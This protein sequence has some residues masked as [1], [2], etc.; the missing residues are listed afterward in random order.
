MAAEATGNDAATGSDAITPFDRC[1]HA[2]IKFKDLPAVGAALAAPG[3]DVNKIYRK[4][5]PLVLAVQM[6]W[7]EGVEVLSGLRLLPSGK[8]NPVA[9][10]ID[11]NAKDGYG[12]APIHYAVLKAD[13]KMVEA[14]LAK[15]AR[16]DTTTPKCQTPLH[17]CLRRENKAVSEIEYKNM[18]AFLIDAGSPLEAADKWGYTAL[19]RAADRGFTELCEHILSSCSRSLN[20]TSERRWGRFSPLMRSTIKG[21]IDTV[22][23]LMA[24]GADIHLKSEDGRQ[25]LNWAASHGHTYICKLLIDAGASLDDTDSIGETA[26]LSAVK[27]YKTLSA[28][29]LLNEG[30]NP[31]VMN[32][33]GEVA[34][35][36]ALK[37]SVL[38]AFE[39][40]TTQLIEA[41]G[42]VHPFENHMKN[43]LDH[44]LMTASS[45]GDERIV[46]LLVG[47]GSVAD[48]R[49][50]RGLNAIYM[51]VKNAHNAVVKLLLQNG[52]D[53]N[54]CDEEGSTILHHVM[55]RRDMVSPNKEEIDVVLEKAV[56]RA[57]EERE[58]REEE[59]RKEE[60]RKKEDEEKEKKDWTALAE[61]EVEEEG[62]KEKTEE[63][64][65]QKFERRKAILSVTDENED[66]KIDRTLE[67]EEKEEDECLT[68]TTSVLDDADAQ[69]FRR[70]FNWTD[71]AETAEKRE[72]FAK[73]LFALGATADTINNRGDT[74]MDVALQSR[75]WL[76][77]RLLV[78]AGCPFT[79]SQHRWLV[80]QSE[81]EAFWWDRLSP[82]ESDEVETQRAELHLETFREMISLRSS[83]LPLKHLMR[84]LIR[85]HCRDRL[86]LFDSAN[87]QVIEIPSSLGRFILMQ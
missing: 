29:Y 85:R 34:L 12:F 18:A 35:M 60:Q 68:E 6:E 8:K 79:E 24:K 30:A 44:P 61:E 4:K 10:K 71:Y 52:A 11:V 86:H 50:H 13:V 66:N 22:R 75:N 47:K 9:S 21:H 56:A 77:S 70:L 49:D 78:L 15:D 26:L 27:S 74:C 62:G 57:A 36:C 81:K 39:T 16:L 58:K 42:C 69:D 25:A 87:S 82:D 84:I 40:V 7:L 67:E 5:T 48:A 28:S 20:S 64:V 33:L 3:A 1:F 65:K 17:L 31:H 83:P 32:T 45:G 63:E 76:C 23:S 14:L 46:A 73:R 43:R 53:V 38:S 2:S 72:V 59:K 54:T 37:F 80:E 51:A 19:H 41:G 55:K